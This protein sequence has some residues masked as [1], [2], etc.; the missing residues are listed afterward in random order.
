MNTAG[1]QKLMHSPGDLEH[2]PIRRGT[3]GAIETGL[4]LF[5]NKRG[6]KVR[7]NFDELECSNSTGT[8]NGDTISV[9][10]VA[11]AESVTD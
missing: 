7:T 4:R 5:V 11:A 6:F 3:G 10:S 2:S 8:A 9:K 1:W